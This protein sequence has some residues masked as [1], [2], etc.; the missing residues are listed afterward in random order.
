MTTAHAAPVRVVVVDSD[1]ELAEAIA[2][3]LVPW[4]FE[5][6]V[7]LGAPVHDVDSADRRASATA[8]RFVVWRE[9]DE[10]I[11]YDRERKAV[12][13]RASRAGA[14]DPVSAAAA[15]LTV[16]TMMRLPPPEPEPEPKPDAS[17]P[18][19]SPP[20]AD[21]PGLR[22]EAGPTL[23][24]AFGDSTMTSLGIAADVLIR[25]WSRGWRFGVG[26]D[27]GTS[28]DINQASFKGTWRD[29]GARLIAAWTH[30]RGR[31][32]LEPRAGLG[33]RWSSLSGTE[34]MNTARD[35]SAI[36]ASA[37]V[38]VAGRARLGDWTIGAV[39]EVEYSFD[40][41]T[42]I[43]ITGAAEIFQVPATALTFGVM[44]SW[45]PWGTWPQETGDLSRA[46]AH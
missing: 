7:D 21:A 4:H 41:P 17:P 28:S 24:V 1:R 44:L 35:E 36:T 13:R 9:G 31:L 16:K 19:V 6:T 20:A 37:R 46:A 10:L 32:E 33:L 12:E 5:I 34:M 40:T 43:K 23:R 30:V 25:P 39:L 2:R 26:G 29:A 15:A 3:A 18:L 14:L 27:L 42:Y 38:G 22:I 45:D 11:V 8:A